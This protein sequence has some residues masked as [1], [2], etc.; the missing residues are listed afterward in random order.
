MSDLAAA[1]LLGRRAED[2][3]P[4]A[5]LLGQARRGEP[6]AE[7]GGGDDVVPAGVAD[8]GQRVVLAQHG[9]GRARAARPAP[10][11]PCRGRR[12]CARR[13]GPRPRAMPVSRSWA[14]CSSK[15]SSGCAWIWC[16]A[17]ISTSARLSTSAATCD[18]ATPS[19]SAAVALMRTVY[20]T[21]M[22]ASGSTRIDNVRAGPTRSPSSQTSR[23][24]DVDLHRG[25]ATLLDLRVRHVGAGREPRAGLEPLAERH[26]HVERVDDRRRPD[27]CGAPTSQSPTHSAFIAATTRPRHQPLAGDEVGDEPVQ[28]AVD[29]HRAEVDRQLHGFGRPQPRLVAGPPSVRHRS[30]P[31]SPS[32]GIGSPARRACSTTARASASVR[33]STPSSRSAPGAPQASP[34]RIVTASPRR[35]STVDAT[36]DAATTPRSRARRP[37]GRAAR[38]GGRRRGAASAD[39]AQQVDQLLDV[40]HEVAAGEVLVV[41]HLVELLARRPGVGE[42]DEAGIGSRASTGARRGPRPPGARPPAAR[43]RRT[44]RA[45]SSTGTTAAAAASALRCS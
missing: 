8:A 10:R 34:L 36:D 17:S 39:L 20:T 24:V 12:R 27:G 16:D 40:A 5:E 29:E 2:D 30:P 23:P 37:P 14:K 11:T 1:A 41:E 32:G 6:G 38:R 42:R 18:R 33:T 7:A 25:D 35:G 9:D 3:D 22:R 31:S 4:A 28:P 19:R 13:R 21:Q 15:P 43:S 44:A 45:P 26:G